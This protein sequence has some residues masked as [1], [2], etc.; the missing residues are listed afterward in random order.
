MQL[1]VVSHL[2]SFAYFVYYVD[3]WRPMRIFTSWLSCYRSSRSSS[4]SGWPAA[5]DSVNTE[6]SRNG[7][8]DCGMANRRAP[9]TCSPC[10][11]STE[12]I[13]IRSAGR[14][15]HCVRRMS[16]RTRTTTITCAPVQQVGLHA[17]LHAMYCFR[18]FIDFS[19]LLE[20]E[21]TSRHQLNCINPFT[22]VF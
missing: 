21:L 17:I 15:F 5:G 11:A 6:E 18:D 2:P 22:P 12:N 7:T 4:C 10:S 8:G 9:A 13:R 14:P 19:G 1:S 20:F 3:R 16:W